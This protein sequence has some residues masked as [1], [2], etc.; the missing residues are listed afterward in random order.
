MLFEKLITYAAVL[1]AAT[2][3]AWR[4]VPGS[5]R[6]TL[7]KLCATLAQRSGLAEATA[8]AIRRRAAGNEGQACGGCAGCGN[9]QTPPESHVITV[10]QNAR[11][12]HHAGSD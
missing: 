4:L 9:R 5:L 6:V 7:A 3:A 12:K 2:Y 1:S 11:G 8:E 10:R